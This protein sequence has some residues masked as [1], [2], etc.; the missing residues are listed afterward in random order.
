MGTSAQYLCL[1]ERTRTGF[2]ETRLDAV[3]FVPMLS[4]LS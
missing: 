1:I 2:T 3:N 4:G